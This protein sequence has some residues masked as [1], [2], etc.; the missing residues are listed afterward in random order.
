MENKIVNLPFP[1]QI[2]LLS[3]LI[4]TLLF[5]S[6]FLFPKWENIIFVGILYVL[7]AL[8]INI[9]ILVNLIIDFITAPSQRKNIAFQMVVVLLNV[10]IAI[11]Y[12]SII[13]Y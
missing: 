8:F 1:I 4:G 2:A 12:F 5:I 13:I 10:P 7:A 3:F 9:I 11:T 6:Y